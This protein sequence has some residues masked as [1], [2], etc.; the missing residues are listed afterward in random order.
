MVDKQKI[1][2]E[3]A[4]VVSDLLARAN[5][6]DGQVLVI[7][8]SSSEIVGQQIGHHLL[9]PHRVTIESG[10]DGGRNI[11]LEFQV[12]LMVSYLSF[13]TLF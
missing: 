12:L 5:L 7:G 11:Q 6:R 10:G 2:A 4:A 3:A 13:Q 9:D 8:C 1:A